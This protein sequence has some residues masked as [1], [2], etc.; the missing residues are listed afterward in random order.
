MLFDSIKHGAKT[1]MPS[2]NHT[3]PQWFSRPKF[4]ISGLK[5]HRQKTNGKGKFK[6]CSVFFR[7]QGKLLVLHSG[8]VFGHFTI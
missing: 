5:I 2:V 3:M 8:S 4:C 6:K 7:G 1:V